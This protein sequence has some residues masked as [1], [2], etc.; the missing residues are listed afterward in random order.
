M[1]FALRVPED[2]NPLQRE[3]QIVPA[4]GVVLPHGKQRLQLDLIPCAV[5]TYNVSLTVDV[6]AV[7]TELL[8]LPIRQVPTG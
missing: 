5:K 7:G 2:L 3:F 1:R 4:T 6:D 8:S